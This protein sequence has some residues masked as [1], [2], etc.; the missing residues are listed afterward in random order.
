VQGL[1][2]V[3]LYT[4]MMARLALEDGRDSRAIEAAGRLSGAGA[5]TLASAAFRLA[6]VLLLAILILLKLGELK[7]RS[8]LMATGP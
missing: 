3:E 6:V 4:V 2:P 8:S 7:V 1:A 5:S